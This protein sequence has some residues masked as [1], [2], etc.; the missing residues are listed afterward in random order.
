MS[1]FKPIQPG[2]D[3]DF[4]TVFKLLDYSSINLNCCINT[5]QLGILDSHDKRKLSNNG[6]L[7]GGGQG[8]LSRK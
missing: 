8:G 5:Q 4:Q 7:G 1:N 6:S 3:Y 2:V